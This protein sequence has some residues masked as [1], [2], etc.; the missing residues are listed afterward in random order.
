MKRKLL[1]IPLILLLFSCEKS[2]EKQVTYYIT[3][4]ISGFDV[5]YRA[6]DGSIRKES[7]V[8]NSAEDEWR[9]SFPGEEGDIVFVSAIY[10]DISSAITVQVLIDGKLFKQGSSSQDTVKYV[11]V[12]GTVPFD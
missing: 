1:L 10:Y 12:S 2:T 7:V 9:Y 6:D 4:S 5:N 3:G 11:T 8:T